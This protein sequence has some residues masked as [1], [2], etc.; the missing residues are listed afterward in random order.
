MTKIGKKSHGLLE[1]IAKASERSAGAYP[2]VST[3]LV[4][5]KRA[6]AL[7]REGLIT[8]FI[9]HNPVHD[10]RWVITREGIDALKEME[11]RS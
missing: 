3:K 1:R 6:N 4:S 2:G 10:E 11:G 8:T 7:H 9:P 5:T